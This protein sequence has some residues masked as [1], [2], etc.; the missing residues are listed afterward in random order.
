MPASRARRASS[1]PGERVGLD[2]HHHDVL[3]V[4][5]NTRARGLIPAAGLPV[6]SI[7]T[8]VAGCAIARHRVV[9]DERGARARGLVERCARA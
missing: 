7:T 9:G 8:S 6:A 4:L 3:A 1:G 5:G 2:V